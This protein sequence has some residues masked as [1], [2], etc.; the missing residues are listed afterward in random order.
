VAG[1]RYRQIASLATALKAL[2]VI[3]I[4]VTVLRGWATWQR[5][6]LLERVRQ[7]RRP[8]IDELQGADDFVRV[9]SGLFLLLLLAIFVVLLVFLWRAAKNTELWQRLPPR[10]GA[11]WAI[12]A[13]FIPFVNLVLPA[14]VVSDIWK[15]SPST[16]SYG[17]RHEESGAVIV[18]WWLT[19]VAANLLARFVAAGDDGRR[20]AAALSSRDLWST[21]SSG[22][23]VVAAV[24]LIVTVQRLAARQAILSRSGSAAVPTMP[25]TPG[26][27]THPV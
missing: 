25:P 5:H 7:G 27:W 26:T 10:R 9:T 13:W 8:G 12:G 18:W 1:G 6:Q 22:F 20:T 16:D 17:Y 14:M 19:W 2:L 23:A 15:R 4:V 11:G 21:V 3:T 24:L